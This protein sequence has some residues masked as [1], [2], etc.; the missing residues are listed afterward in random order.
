MSK[1]D[2]VFGPLAAPLI[3]EWGQ[4]AVFVQQQSSA[5]DPST[6]VVTASKKRTNVKVVITRIDINE[7]GGL[8]QESD[9]K[10][11]IDAQ[12]IKSNYITTDDYFEV[13]T[14]GSTQVMKVIEPRTYRGDKPVFFSVIARP[15]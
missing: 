11:L 8:Y 12:Q 10:I 15:E 7:T 14:A 4:P 1:V 5:Y 9:V 3:K 13:L 2:D 6:G